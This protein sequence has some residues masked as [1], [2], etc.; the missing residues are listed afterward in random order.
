MSQGR[1]VVH[2]GSRLGGQLD[3]TTV[4]DRMRPDLQRVEDRLLA[5]TALEF[6]IVSEILQALVRAGGKRLRPLLL[7]LAAKPF[8]YDLERL[9]PLP[10]SNCFTR[11]H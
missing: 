4:L 11:P 2:G 3:F 8:R 1:R 6:P 9:P 5:E 10:G 7:L